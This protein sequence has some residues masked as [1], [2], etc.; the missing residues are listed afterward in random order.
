MK[1][2]MTS[3]Q[4]VQFVIC[5]CHACYVAF[6]SKTSPFELCCDQAFVMTNMLY[7]FGNFFY[8]SYIA[9]KKGRETNKTK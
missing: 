3:C 7:L 1:I 8:K 4:M 9:G 5:L 2:Y 6:Y